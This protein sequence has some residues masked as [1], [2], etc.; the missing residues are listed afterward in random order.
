VE[1]RFFPCGS[2]DEIVLWKIL[3]LGGNHGLKR[4]QMDAIFKKFLK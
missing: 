2:C 1:N 4:S 3:L